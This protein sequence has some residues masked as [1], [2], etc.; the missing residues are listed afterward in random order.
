MSVSIPAGF[1]ALHLRPNPY[2][3]ACGPLYGRLDAGQLVLGLRVEHR[4][5]NPGGTCHGG[6]L[7]TLADMLLVL[8]A[9]LQA[10][11]TR[12]MLTVNLNCD[13]IGPAA[14]GSWLE[15]RLQVLRRTRSL[16]FCQ[17]AIHA[18]GALVLRLNGIAK[19]SG[20]PDPSFSPARL[21]GG[22]AQP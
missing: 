10:G 3:E 15:G 17:G 18:D 5:C 8:G 14:H 21:M 20:E 12:Y 4:H 16:V 22:A 19:P 2:I 9:T 7:T 6:M 1:T 13:F 11:D